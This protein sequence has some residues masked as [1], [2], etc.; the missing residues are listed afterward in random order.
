MKPRRLVCA[1]DDGTAISARSER[2]EP[3]PKQRGQTVGVATRLP[4]DRALERGER[5]PTVVLSLADA[6]SSADNPAFTRWLPIQH[7]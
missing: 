2:D 5:R 6:L 4:R 7:R 3:K 1:T